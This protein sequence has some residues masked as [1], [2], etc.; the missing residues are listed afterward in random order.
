MQ[1]SRDDYNREGCRYPDDICFLQ[2]SGS[3]SEA[4]IVAL[5]AIQGKAAAPVAVA[6]RAQAIFNLSLMGWERA[7][8][9][10]DAERPTLAKKYGKGS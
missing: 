2:A 8:E 7:K 1:L 3:P 5:T 4:A 9:A 10:W 6:V